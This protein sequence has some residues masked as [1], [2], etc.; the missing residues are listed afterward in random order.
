MYLFISLLSERRR[1]EKR[2]GWGGR[3]LS[4]FPLCNTSCSGECLALLMLSGSGSYCGLRSLVTRC[5][6]A[7]QSC[8]QHPPGPARPVGREQPQWGQWGT[9]ERGAAV[10][11]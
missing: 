6:R 2:R 8:S 10:S 4:A 7:V 5:G 9:G 3:V 1:A 11:I